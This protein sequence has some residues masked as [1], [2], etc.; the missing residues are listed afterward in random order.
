MSLQ[1]RSKSRVVAGLWMVLWLVMSIISFMQWIGFQQLQLEQPEFNT[2]TVSRGTLSFSTQWKSSG[3]NAVIREIDGSE[4]QLTCGGPYYEQ[5]CFRTRTIE[6]IRRDV[7]GK[8]ATVWWSPNPNKKLPGLLYQLEVDGRL[9][10]RYADQ[11][12]KY[13]D[14]YRKGPPTSPLVRT[15]VFLLLTIPSLKYFFSRSSNL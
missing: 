15:A 2:L 10:Y 5:E 12:T 11:A 13:L 7:S 9:I 6:D 1:A 4:I 8:T 3:G 14:E